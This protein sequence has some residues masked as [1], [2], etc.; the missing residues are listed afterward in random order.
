[1]TFYVD[2]HYD[3]VDA[4]DDAQDDAHDAAPAPLDA[5][6]PSRKRPFEPDPSAS[7]PD[8]S[9]SKVDPPLFLTEGSG[10]TKEGDSSEAKRRR[11]EL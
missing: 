9:P 5:Q 1:V 7:T 11:K 3:Q 4:H 10:V 2:E 8:G 6:T